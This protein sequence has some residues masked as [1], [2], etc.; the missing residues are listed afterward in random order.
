MS[1]FRICISD[2]GE[3]TEESCSNT[4]GETGEYIPPPEYTHKCIDIPCECF[5]IP[6]EAN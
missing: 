1:C 6:K 2:V 3:E 4:H 5:E